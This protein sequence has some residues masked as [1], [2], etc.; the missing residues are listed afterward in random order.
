MSGENAKR[1]GK[2]PTALCHALAAKSRDP[3]RI[4]E[5]VFNVATITVPP[6]GHPGGTQ[7]TDSVSGT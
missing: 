3:K 6:L 4:V 7:M 5:I 2:S 1:R